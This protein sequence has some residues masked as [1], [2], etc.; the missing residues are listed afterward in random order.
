MLQSFLNFSASRVTGVVKWFNVKSGYGFINRD[1]FSYIS[2]SVSL[3]TKNGRNKR[4]L[5]SCSQG[6]QR[7]RTVGVGEAL[8]GLL[9]LLCL[10]L[11]IP[12]LAAKSV[13]L[14]AGLPATP[15]QTLHQTA[16]ITET[17]GMCSL[18]HWPIEVKE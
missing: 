5:D 1:N 6:T 2:S 11:D 18:S 14:S 9:A 16:E 12:L 17:P 3:S 7:D 10:S 4:I 13:C 15:T 8:V